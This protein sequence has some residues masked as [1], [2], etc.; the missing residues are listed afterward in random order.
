MFPAALHL[1]RRHGP[2]IGRQIDLAPERAQNLAGAC[3][4]QRGKFERSCSHAVPAP[5]GGKERRHIV[6]GQSRMVG[7]LTY[8]RAGRQDMGEIA[9]PHCRVRPLPKAPHRRGVEHRLDPAAHP[10]RG[11][12]LLGPNR[13]KHLNNKAGI[14]R[15]NR[16]FPES[17]VDVSGEGIVPL[18]PVLRVAPADPV[19]LDEL[20]GTLA[21]GAALRDGESLR[22]QLG[23]LGVERID[24]IKALLAV[25]C[26]PSACFRE[27]DIGVR[28][29][30]H[31]A[32]LAVKLEPEHPRFGAGRGDAEIKPAAVMQDRRP[33]RL[34]H[35]HRRKFA[36]VRHRRSR[37]QFGEGGE[38]VLP[39]PTSFPHSH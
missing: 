32:A 39:F 4:C 35:F 34:C 25:I 36:S 16:Q 15:R 13:I 5:Q 26:R 8:F 29:K 9:F 23:P 7:D 6:K 28:A 21:E 38:S 20:G 14:N 18:L 1:G 30:P 31:V 37:F 3:R 24:P 10:A 17:G 33:L 11:F 2:Y 19:P 12:R 27:R 22:L